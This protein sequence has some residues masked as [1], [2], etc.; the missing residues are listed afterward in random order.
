M[1]IPSS[2]RLEGK[3]GNLYALSVLAAK[4][5]R[6]LKDPEVRKLVGTQSSHPLTIALEEIAEE[7]IVARYV[8]TPHEEPEELAFEAQEVT[9]IAPEAEEEKSPEATV[10]ELLG[11]GQDEDKAEMKAE[12]EETEEGEETE[13]AEEVKDLFEAIA[14]GDVEPVVVSEE[15]EEEEEVE[16]KEEE[17]VEEEEEEEVEGKEEPEEHEGYKESAAGGWLP[18][19]T[20]DEKDE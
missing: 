20:G 10:R 18:N 9:L 8:E 6:Q 5:A 15:D 7:K 1:I 14:S 12:A 16:G 4:R 11:I 2:D 3:T 13:E 17:N 19:E